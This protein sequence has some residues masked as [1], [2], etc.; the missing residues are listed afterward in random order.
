MRFAQSLLVALPALAV[1]QEQVPLADRVKG[2]FN[3]AQNY[4][5]E[6]VPAV[7]APVDAGAAKVAE[8]VVEPLT[9]E[10]WRSV[11]NSSNVA[12]VD[13]P[14]EWMVFLTGGNKTC[15]GLCGNVT[16]AWNKSAPIIAA[17]P[18][19]PK[20]ATI[21]CDEEGILCNTWAASPP[22]IVHMLLP[23]PLPDQSKPATTVR[24]IPLNRTSTT[25]KDIAEIHS[26][27]KYEEVT[28]YEGVF[29]PFD[30]ALVQY[31]VSVPAAYFFY[32]FSKMPS[33]LPM[34]AISL[35]SRTFM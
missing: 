31:G 14:E 30:G 33:W 29:H 32:Y 26:L 21:D 6:S 8:V 24:Y 3:K 13:G 12:T 16:E 7:T 34:V 17:S 20:L 10:N 5:T 25:A 23:A 27:K 15:F 22:S 9:L 19:P 11:I 35:L 4:V 2:W 28:P 18:S 1:A